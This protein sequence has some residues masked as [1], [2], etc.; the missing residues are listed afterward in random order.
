MDRLP[1]NSVCGRAMTNGS[2]ELERA[3]HLLGEAIGL[4]CSVAHMTMLEACG[5]VRAMPLWE[6][7]EQSRRA[8][9]GGDAAVI[10]NEREAL[11]RAILK[12]EQKKGIR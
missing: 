11:E 10:D 1:H 9:A 8:L 5:T 12:I 6:A 4:A 2:L 3:R 7:I